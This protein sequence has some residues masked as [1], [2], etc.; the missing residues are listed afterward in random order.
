MAKRGTV[1]AFRAFYF[2]F[3]AFTVL[4]AFFFVPSPDDW[5]WATGD[6][7]ALLQRGFADYNGRYLGNLFA[8]ALLRATW[9]LPPAKALVL[10]GILA[11][12]QKISGNQDVRFL[13][14]CAIAL[15][16]PCPLFIQ[17]IVWTSAFTNYEIPVALLLC[18]AYLV[19]FPKT[20]TSRWKSFLRCAILLLLGFAGQLFMEHYTLF[21]LGLA[22]FAVLFHRRKTGRFLLAPSLWLCAA[23]AGAVLMF[24]NGAYLQILRGEQRYQ[25]LEWNPLATLGSIAGGFLAA[26]LPA[27]LLLAFLLL[28]LRKRNR[29]AFAAIPKSKT[30]WFYL[31]ALLTLTAPLAVVFPVGSRCFSMAA[32]LLLLAAQKLFA[33]AAPAPSAT[34]NRGLAIALAFVMALDLAGYATVFAAYRHKIDRVRTQVAQGNTVITLRHTPLRFLVYALD[35]EPK[36]RSI[37]S[38]FNQY[39]GLPEDVKIEYL[40]RGQ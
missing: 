3:F 29:R 33:A 20:Q 26:C 11:L 36:S 14:L 12:L 21:A 6:G 25:R 8:F 38:A 9:L 31:A 18:C 35:A 22:G 15:L 39:Y 32:V 34:G 7:L 30:A 5:G 28:R 10:T 16:L 4:L 40:N 2:V 24:S 17:N 23:A 1:T 19:F 13:R 37:Q 27:L